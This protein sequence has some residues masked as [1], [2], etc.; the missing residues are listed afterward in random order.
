MDDDKKQNLGCAWLFG[1]VLLAGLISSSLHVLIDPTDAE[2]MQACASA[3]GG[4]M[5]RWER[6]GHACQCEAP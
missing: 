6:S 3:C 5:S 2:L 4:R 1:L